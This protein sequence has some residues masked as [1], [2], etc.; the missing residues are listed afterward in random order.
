MNKRTKIL[1]ATSIPT[2][3]ISTLS[4]PLALNFYKTTNKQQTSI[5]TSSQTQTAFNEQEVVSELLNDVFENDEF[6]IQSYVFNQNLIADEKI[7]ELK[8]SLSYFNTQISE[9]S[10]KI[11]ALA[12]SI[13]NYTT[14]RTSG[15]SVFYNMTSNWL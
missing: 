7:D 8:L 9:I 3:L 10:T 12:A 15:E 13:A 1:L 6:K 2:T 4:I 14:V 11:G 5:K